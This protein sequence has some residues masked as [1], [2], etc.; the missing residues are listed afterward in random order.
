MDSIK[1]INGL[2]ICPYCKKSFKSLATHTRQ[3]HNIT[4]KQLKQIFKLPHSFSFESK[5][6]KEN[7]RN[8]AL[9]YNMDEQLKKAGKKTRFKLSRKLSKA[10]KNS[11]S[12]G[13]KRIKT[14][15]KIS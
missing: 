13:H 7:R 4:S 15:K 5:E 9:F 1:I 3:T 2:F 12:L 10:Q 8:K 11:I 14:I 6:V